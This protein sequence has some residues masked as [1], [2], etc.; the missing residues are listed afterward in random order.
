[1][2]AR[3][4]F[5]GHSALIPEQYVYRNAIGIKIA[6]IAIVKIAEFTIEP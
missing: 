1:M 3:V 5:P 2:N 4:A 6:I